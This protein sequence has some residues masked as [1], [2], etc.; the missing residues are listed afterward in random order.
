VRCSNVAIQR[1]APSVNAKTY[2]ERGAI[3]NVV[4]YYFIALELT[5]CDGLAGHSVSEAFCVRLKSQPPSVTEPLH[6]RREHLPSGLATRLRSPR[7]PSG[8]SQS[9]DVARD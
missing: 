1:R 6:F 2:G 8:H 9:V 3:L 7:A 4:H 5:R